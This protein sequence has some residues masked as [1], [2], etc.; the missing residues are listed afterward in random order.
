LF[1]LGILSLIYSEAIFHAL[2]RF[3]KRWR[4]VPAGW[5]ILWSLTFIV[6]FPPLIGYSTCVTLA[7]FVYGF[8]NG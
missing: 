4:D 5:L 8:P 6:S 3:A 2:A 7:G 1:V